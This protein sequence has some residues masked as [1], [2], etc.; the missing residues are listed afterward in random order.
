MSDEVWRREAIESPCVKLCV[1]HPTAKLCLGCLRTGDEI[2]AWGRLTPE[3]RREIMAD[4][5]SR[6]STLRKAVEA[7]RPSRR[8][9]RD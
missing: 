5:P 3:R 4:L 9:P 2:A 6:A 1:L 8:R 7:D